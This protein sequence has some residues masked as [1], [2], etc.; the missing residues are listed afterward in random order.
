MSLDIDAMKEYKAPPAI[1]FMEFL[2][3]Q[4]EGKQEIFFAYRIKAVG[5]PVPHVGKSFEGKPKDERH[6]VFEILDVRPEGQGVPRLRGDKYR[7]EFVEVG[8]RY[9]ADLMRHKPLWTAFEKLQ[10]L[11]G[12]LFAVMNR[13]KKKGKSGKPYTDYVVLP[14]E[15]EMQAAQ[16]TFYE[17]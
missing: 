5:E 1:P 17:E 13:G 11:N 16:I 3:P 10:P 14:S 12:H 15:G 4:K 6:E 8:K 2:A 9:K 7:E